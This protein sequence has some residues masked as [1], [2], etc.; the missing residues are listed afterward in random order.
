MA[1]ILH[2]PAIPGALSRVRERSNSFV[3]F[4]LPNTGKMADATC[5][6]REK[7][8]NENEGK[9]KKGNGKSK[10]HFLGRILMNFAGY[11]IIVKITF[12][13]LVSL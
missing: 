6:K 4:N 7:M 1:A 11:G 8:W 3:K 2:N 5:K 9:G 10:N 13:I 12:H